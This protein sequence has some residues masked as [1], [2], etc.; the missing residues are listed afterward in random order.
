MRRWIWI[1]TALL[2]LCATPAAQARETGFL[3]RSLTVEGVAFP[4]QVYV[5]KGYDRSKPLPII[6]FLHGA[7]ERG[8]D[9]LIQTEV[10]IGSA[11]RR[12]ADRYPAIVVFP[13]APRNTVW[14]E[15][16]ARAA[17]AALDAATREFRADRSRQ[18][19]TGLSM[20]GNGAWYLAFHHPDRWAAMVVICGFVAPRPPFVPAIAPSEPDPYAAIA[21]RVAKIP[22]TIVHGDADPVVSVE[23]SRRMAAALKAAGADVAYRELPGVDHNSWDPAFQGEELP[24]WLFSKRKP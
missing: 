18:Y 7:G 1:V 9:G 11:I 4:Y 10:G 19:L 24:A 23:E 6:L 17:L 8:T 22:V 15:R 2:M 12:H 21:R 3:D 5:P 16:P 13:Q 14:Q 20:G